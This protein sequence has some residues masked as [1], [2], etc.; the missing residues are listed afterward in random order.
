MRKIWPGGGAAPLQ[1]VFGY[2]FLYCIK[3]FSGNVKKFGY[4]E[5]LL[6]TNSFISHVSSALTVDFPRET[7]RS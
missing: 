5:D 7:T 2:I 6:T 1:R 4:N 3:I